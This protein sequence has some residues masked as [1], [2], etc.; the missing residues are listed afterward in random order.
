ARCSRSEGGANDT[1]ATPGREG[2]RA[3]AL[4]PR[5]GL[6]ARAAARGRR[7]RAARRVDARKLRQAAPEGAVR[8]HG[9]VAARAA[10]PAVVEVRT[11]EV[12]AHARSAEAL[13][14]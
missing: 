5:R 7:A 13:R 2:F 10:R 14:R 3:R 8:P 12:R 9:H 1:V 11:G 6:R 4:E